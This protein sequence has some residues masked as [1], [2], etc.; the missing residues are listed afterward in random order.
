MAE[1]NLSVTNDR[2][3]MVEKL[4]YKIAF[5]LIILPFAMLNCGKGSEQAR[6]KL[7]QLNIPYTEDSFIEQA[8]AG[9]TFVLDLFLTSG[10]NI[11]TKGKYGV[12]ALT[13]A[14]GSGKTESVKFLLEKGANPNSAPNIGKNGW[15]CI[16]EA[17]EQGHI[18]ILKL[19]V[20]NSANLNAPD[21]E[22]RTP[23]MIAAKEGQLEIAKVLISSGAQLNIQNKDSGTALMWAAYEGHHDVVKLLIQQGA[24]F[25]VK[26]KHAQTALLIASA[27]KNP[28][29]A[30]M[31]IEEGADVNEKDDFGQT[32]RMYLEQGSPP[33][34][35]GFDRSKSDPQALQVVDEMWESLGGK[36]NWQKTRFLSYHWIVEVNGEIRSDYRHDWDRY[37]ND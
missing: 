10:M 22:G 4:S 11:N 33:A 12:T 1:N 14:V 29:I 30:Q 32:A 2:G 25:Q 15:T 23:L 8:E 26:N 7:G 31:L 21:K 18:E 13:A 6:L 36:D 16:M 9:D 5:W 3:I 20:Q 35:N 34:E 28:Q 17:V 19:L 27:Q 37:T 24:D